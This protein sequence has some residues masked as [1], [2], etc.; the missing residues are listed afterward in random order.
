M[1]MSAEYLGSKVNCSMD[2]VFDQ[3]FDVVRFGHYL[4]RKPLGGRYFLEGQR[5]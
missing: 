5:R 3:T 4:E 1:V 2:G